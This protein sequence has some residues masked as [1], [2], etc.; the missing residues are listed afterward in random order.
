MTSKWRTIIFRCEAILGI[1]FK[2]SNL[3]TW[4][5]VS[6]NPD[7]V[8]F[9]STRP[10]S[11]MEGVKLKRGEQD[12]GNREQEDQRQIQQAPRSRIN[13]GHAFFL[14][15]NPF[16]ASLREMPRGMS[17]LEAS[18]GLHG[19]E[20]ACFSSGPENQDDCS[21]SFSRSWTELEEK[22]KVMCEARLGFR[23]FLMVL[24]WR[25][26]KVI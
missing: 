9:C 16:P 11:E 22:K 14:K 10:S 23:G 18:Q 5:S 1:F 24:L 6:C 20:V 25:Q 15:V 8:G 19:P 13:G 2:A 7:V 21:G 4:M 17:S 12:S 3:P 26:V